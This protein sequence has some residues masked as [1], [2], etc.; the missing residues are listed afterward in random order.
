MNLR[1]LRIP[2]P[3]RPH[4][5]RLPLALATV[6]AVGV[7]G[8]FGAAVPAQAATQ[9]PC[10]IFSSGGTPCVAAY[11]MVRA[12]YGSY[13]GPL[14]QIERASDDT[15]AT[16]GLLTAGGY[17]NSAPQVSFC[18]NT[19]CTVTE[20]YD[21]S[22]EGNN[23]PVSI[24]GHWPGPGTNG[25]DVPANAMA[26]PVAVNGH[27]AYGLKVNPGVGYRIDDAAGVA[28][29]SEPEGIYE[30]TSGT[31]SNSG[32]CFDFGS[33]ETSNT[34]TGS[35]H[36]N[37]IYWGTSCWFGG[38]TGNGPWVEADLENGLYSSAT[39]PNSAGNTG[40][41]DQFVSAWEKNNGTSTF[42]LKY[43]NAQSGGLTT[44]YSGGLPSGY[45]P[46]HEENSILLGVGGDN[47]VSG[48][49]SFFEGAM[50]AGYPTDATENAVQA[51]IT[52]AKYTAP[53]TPF[54]PGARISIQATTAC[55]TGDYIQHD[56][57]DTKVVIAP[58]TS[59][60]STQDK[61]DATWIVTTGLANPLCISLESANESGEYLRH[62]GFELWLE[63]SDGTYQFAQDATF[64]PVPGNS[65]TGYS[66]Q[67]INYP[68]HFIRHYDYTV[69]AAA[70]GGSNAWDNPTL[71]PQDT[72]WLAASAWS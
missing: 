58:V 44:T 22:S 39:G 23:L 33:G 8:L 26:L 67:S 4:G 11:S 10:D 49:G 35:G 66:L 65:G 30:V 36:M 15:T 19:T 3:L 34:D 68:D 24:G 43:G 56:A 54:T 71:W 9:G 5:R 25:A 48:D 70:D 20:L 14:Y 50:T 53:T 27:A 32:C 40:V 60:S 1:R 52:T 31:I 38:C 41:Q 61:A 69:Y 18:A 47:S 21:Q 6:C 42:T 72:S 64:C 17:V 29:G 62:Y 16:I 57:S 2:K 37:A 13:D 45:A 55:C 46:M 12:M 63:P 51:D 7:A 59:A 28:T